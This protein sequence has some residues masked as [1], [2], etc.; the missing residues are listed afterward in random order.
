MDQ[1]RPLDVTIIA[2]LIIVF[3]LA[4]IVTGFTHNFFGLHTAQGAI[5]AYVGAMIGALYAAAGVLI[6]TM[7][8]RMA[9]WA[10]VLLVLVI[11][12]RIAM[13]VSGLYPLE[14]FRQ[15]AAIV[16]GTSI[17]VGF[18]LYIGMRRSAF[19]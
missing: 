19:R 12:G 7:N 6:F 2:S 5:S 11:V 16:L 18:A 10:L 13:I 15:T 9:I 8:R 4:E 14:T 1:R 17:A 3:G